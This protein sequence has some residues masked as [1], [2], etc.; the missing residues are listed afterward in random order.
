MFRFRNT[1]VAAGETERELSRT[2]SLGESCASGRSLR[3]ALPYPTALM[4]MLLAGLALMLPNIQAQQPVAA[5]TKPLTAGLIALKNQAGKGDG[6]AQF[7]LGMAYVAGQE[8]EQDLAQAASW[9]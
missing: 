1:P 6:A 4:A 8:V 2:D 5:P 7:K 9:W 3:T